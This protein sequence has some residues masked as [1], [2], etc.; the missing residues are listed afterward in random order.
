MNRR[1]IL[2]V[3]DDQNVLAGL[4]NLLRKQRDLWEMLFSG[5]GIEALAEMEKAPVDVIVTDMR[6]PGMDG[7][8]LL[9]HVKDLYPS[10]VRI[11]LSGYADR[12]AVARVV[13]VAHQFLSKP[14]EADTVRAVIE[15]ACGLQTLLANTYLQRVVGTIDQ[16]PALSSHYWVLAQA[17]AR[18]ESSIADIAAIVE[19]DP[20]MSLKVLQLVN[21]AYFGMSQRTDSIPRAVAYLGLD[22]LKG[23]VLA[24]HVFGPEPEAGGAGAAADALD[25]GALRREALLAANLARRI[26]GNPAHRDAAFTA[27]L[28]HDIGQVV[29]W[30]APACRYGDVLA[31][32]RQ[33]HR[34]LRDVEHE[35]IGTTHGVAGAYLLGVWGLPYDLAEVVAFH[36]SPGSVEGGDVTVLAAVHLAAAVA[37]AAIAG[38]EP[39]APGNDLDQAF[40]ERAGLWTELPRWRREAEQAARAGGSPSP[41]SPQLVGSSAPPRGS[42]ASEPSAR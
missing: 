38:V 30:R 1:R 8:T 31:T 9:R 32:R 28:V 41:P 15:R 12:L 25:L 18:P 13:A 27:G 35:M 10:T 17:I 20:A 14:A 4:R 26:V 40:L 36:D 34:A 42:G 16:L 5:G 29:L 24:A 6:M 2:F 7:G 11:V 33:S 19:G 21:S 23:L 22:N 37:E 39:T 3:D